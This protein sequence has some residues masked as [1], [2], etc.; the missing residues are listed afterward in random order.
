MMDGLGKRVWGK[1]HSEQFT[2]LMV[3]VL[4]YLAGAANDLQIVG[5]G[6]LC[7]FGIIYENITTT[8]FTTRLYRSI[9]AQFGITSLEQSS[10]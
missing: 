1:I 10:M 9:I 8:T 2:L 6:T 7:V 4:A 5:T 3:R